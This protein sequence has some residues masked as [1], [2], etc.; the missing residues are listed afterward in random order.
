MSTSLSLEPRAVRS[1]ILGA[2]HDGTVRLRTLRISQKE[3]SY[4]VLLKRLI[5]AVGG[6]AWTYR[7]GSTRDLYVV[8]FGRVFLE[9]HRVLTGSDIVYYV[10][11][12]FDAEGG[13]ADSAHGGPYVYFAQKDRHDLEELRGFIMGLG[14]SC[15]KIHNPSWRADPRYWRFYIS[16]ESILRFSSIVG[17]WHPRKLRIL[18]ALNKPEAT[19]SARP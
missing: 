14:I 5:E 13:A 11:G 6:R 16:R 15:G 12:Y 10:R 9:G 2:M 4:V 17:S 3:E 19:Q 18:K 7:E 1:Y 8:E